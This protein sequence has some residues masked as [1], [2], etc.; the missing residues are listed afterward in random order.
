MN[1]SSAVIVQRLD[2]VPRGPDELTAEVLTQ[3]LRS[4]AGRPG[5]KVA[6][7]RW[8]RIGQD[9]GF[10]GVVA[11]GW[12]EWEPQ[13]PGPASVIA[14]FPLLDDDASGFRQVMRGRSAMRRR[15]AERAA[16]EVWFYEHVAPGI[17]TRVPRCWAI[18]AGPER[19]RLVLLLEDVDDGHPGDA[20]TGCSPADAA[21]VLDAMA[22]LHAAFWAR[23]DRLAQLASWSGGPADRM[24]R[25]E[26]FAQRW[27]TLV[28]SGAELPLRIR[29]MAEHLCGRLAAVL[30]RLEAAP[31]TLL[32]ADLHLDNVL[33]TPGAAR[34][35]VVVLDWQSVC[36]GP[37]VADVAPFIATSL[38]LPDRRDRQEAMLS[39]YIGVLLDHGV[40]EED[41]N[42]VRAGFVPALLVRFAGVVGW[43][44]ATSTVAMTGRETALA[45]AALGDGRLVAA[46][47]DNG[48]DILLRDL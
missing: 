44:A 5:A 27:R 46:L 13:G 48:A 29:R 41:A 32:H 16:R 37:A 9:R 8:E 20:L 47:L 10:T 39:R 4:T 3:A 30:E 28:D 35:H 45:E 34:H 6:R 25:Q 38:S 42:W 18:G 12:L 1:T 21:L 33:F 31:R 7:V 19:D 23:Q 11:R 36:Q 24:D 15:Y 14:K 40:P 26:R 22:P 2:E 17:S 43:R